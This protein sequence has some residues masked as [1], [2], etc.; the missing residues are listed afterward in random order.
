MWTL[1]RDGRPSWANARTEMVDS[2]R[3]PGNAQPPPGERRRRKG[4]TSPPTS[5]AAAMHEMDRPV[6]PATK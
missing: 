6:H 4:V 3:E 1:A 5:R 2:F